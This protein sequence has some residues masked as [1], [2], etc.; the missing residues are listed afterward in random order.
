MGYVEMLFAVNEKGQER[1]QQQPGI[2]SVSKG[3]DA[4]L[5]V[6]GLS[7]I[8]IVLFSVLSFRYCFRRRFSRAKV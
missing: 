6:V 2:I 3:G 4:F 1:M 8:T 7:T 5:N